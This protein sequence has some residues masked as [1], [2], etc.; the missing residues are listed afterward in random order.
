M[1]T[2]YVSR[3]PPIAATNGLQRPRGGGGKKSDAIREAAV[4]ALLEAKTIAEAAAHCRI[5]ER[6]RRRW[7]P[8]DRDFQQQYE[9]ARNVTFRRPCIACRP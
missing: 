5:G 1:P 2:A 4:V 8:E 9:T 7:V 6:T 3:G